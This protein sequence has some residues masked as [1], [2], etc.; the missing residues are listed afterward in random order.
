MKLTVF[1]DAACSLWVGVVEEHENNKLKARRHIF[2]PEPKD[3][4]VLFFVN[5]AMLPLMAQA[6]Q[7]VDTKPMAERRLNP[8]RMAREA[9]R[10]L[11]QRG[12]STFAQEAIKLELL[13]R[14]KERKTTSRERKEEQ[15]A[16]KREIARQKAKQ[17]HRGK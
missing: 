4:E 12:I 15:L 11:Q 5:H 6:T 13:Q 17:K 3:A 9:N 8:K 2:G 14:K 7:L 1:F 10:E 16:Y